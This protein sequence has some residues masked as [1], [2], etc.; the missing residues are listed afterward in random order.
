LSSLGGGWTPLK[1][2]PV[3]P[4]FIYNNFPPSSLIALPKS[5]Y[6]FGNNSLISSVFEGYSNDSVEFL[7]SINILNFQF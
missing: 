1:V 4:L 2:C 6:F 3:D 5:I 7:K